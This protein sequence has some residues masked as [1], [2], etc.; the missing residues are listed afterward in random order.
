LS[1]SIDISQALKRQLRTGK[2][3][4]KLIPRVNCKPTALGKGDTFFTVDQMKEW[5]EK[6]SFQTMALAK[7]LK[8]K[9]LKETV[10]NIYNF[11]YNHIQYTADGETQ[12]LLSPACAWKQRHAGLDCKSF[13][14]FASSILL[15]LGIE[16]LIRQIKQPG[17]HPNEFTHVYVV[18]PHKNSSN[19]FIIDAT[20]HQNV[21]SIY[22]EKADQI[23]NKLTH[24]GLNAPATTDL[25][26]DQIINSFEQF[27]RFLIEK[28]VSVDTVN[29]IRSHV[30]AF[31]S[32][33]RDPKFRIYDRG[34]EVEGRKYPISFTRG[35]NGGSGSGSGS[36]EAEMYMEAG[37]ALMEMLPAD[38]IENTFASVFANGFDV[39]C[40]NASYSTS[41]AQAALTSDIPYM[42]REYSGLAQNPS[43]KTLNSFLNAIGGYISDSI[44]GQK[45]KFA[46]C[47]REGYAARQKGA[48]EARDMVLNTLKRGGYELV[49]IGPRKGEVNM[50]VPSYKG[51]PFRWGQT[52]SNSYEFIAY[53]LKGSGEFKY[54]AP[55]TSSG[56][57]NNGGSNNGGSYSGGSYNGGSGN[58]V[59]TN[60]G[61]YNGGSDNGG[62]NTKL[63]IAAG[64]GLAA[65]PFVLPMIKGGQMK[66]AI[67]K[68]KGKK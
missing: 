65:L 67:S 21:E 16:H 40:W 39:T 3:Y 22:I 11:L 57:S 13:S 6:Y 42:V 17:F 30:S 34:I 2:E 28:G 31:T 24:V 5:I 37:K 63:L 27:C 53:E 58:Y 50:Q 7:K 48:E 45:A 60:N 18:I 15:N 47:T 62:S 68:A 29:A 38:F 51:K 10:D 46:K 52:P 4:D 14:V 19:G 33:G 12:R 41:K 66:A 59:P 25:R 61:S 35:L 8:G 36:G 20:K 9:G 43:T 1:N 55:V 64:V 23:M 26:T 54:T 56:G 32:V 49:P 44:N